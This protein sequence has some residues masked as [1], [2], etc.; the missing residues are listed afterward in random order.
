MAGVPMSLLSLG[1]QNKILLTKAGGFG[2]PQLFV[3]VA[4][5]MVR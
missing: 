2:S 1:G 4:E 5:G 3:D